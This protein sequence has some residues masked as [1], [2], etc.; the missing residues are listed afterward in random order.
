MMKGMSQMLKQ[1]QAMQKQ[2]ADKQAEIANMEIEG[3]AG[4][5]LVKATLT[6][7]HD[8]KKLTID[9]SLMD[10]REMLED[11]IIASVNDANKKLETATQEM[12]A[13]V[14]SGLPAGMKLPF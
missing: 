14:S 8:M 10:D 1:A 3:E 12:M 9:D 4:A 6:G 11:L 2:I 13:E 7:R 5:G